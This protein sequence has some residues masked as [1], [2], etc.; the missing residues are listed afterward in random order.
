LIG[1]SKKMK[2]ERLKIIALPEWRENRLF[3]ARKSIEF[4]VQFPAPLKIND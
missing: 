2:R 1:V 3:P 4:P